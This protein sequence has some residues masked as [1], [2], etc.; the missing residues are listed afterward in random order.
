VAS[1]TLLQQNHP[2]LNWASAGV[3]RL[4]QVVLYNRHKKIV[5]VVAAAVDTVIVYSSP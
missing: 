1:K 3:D 2:L 5:V 4:R